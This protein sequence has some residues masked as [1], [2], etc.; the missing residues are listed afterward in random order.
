MLTLSTSCPVASLW[1]GQAESHSFASLGIPKY[2]S[3]PEEQ[4]LA[5]GDMCVL[6]GAEGWD[7]I[8]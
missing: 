6:L 5:S 4:L 2:Q 8:V 1:G 3:F 7:P